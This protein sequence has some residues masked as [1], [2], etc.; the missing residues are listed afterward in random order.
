MYIDQRTCIAFEIGLDLSTLSYCHL[1][2][3]QF[4]TIFKNIFI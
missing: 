2:H 1:N 4:I 3:F